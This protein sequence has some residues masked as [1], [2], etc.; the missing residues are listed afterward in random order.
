MTNAILVSTTDVLDGWSIAQHLGIVS[1]HVV[2]GTNVFSDIFASISDIFGGR[3]HTYQRYL[4]D[5]EKEVIAI[6]S[7]KAELLGA[8]CVI[9]LRI[10]HDELS[11]GGKSMFMV[12]AHGTAVFAQRSL[13]G[14]TISL[15]SSEAI[16]GRDIHAI[17][18]KVRLLREAEAGELVLTSEVVD[19]LA[20]HRFPDFSAFFVKQIL[21]LKGNDFSSPIYQLAER[22]FASLRDSDAMPGLYQLAECGVVF[23]SNMIRD[24]SLLDLDRARSMLLSGNAEIARRALEMLTHTKLHYRIEDTNTLENISSIVLELFPEVPISE[25]KGLFSKTKQVWTCSCG[26]NNEPT[27][28]TCAGCL[29]DR[30]GFLPAA[31]KPEYVADLLLRQ[32]EAIR[33]KCQTKT[34]SDTVAAA[35]T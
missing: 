5:I 10:D 26:G 23:A 2:A 21:E 17:A 12:T 1:G 28:A 32:V 14:T 15:R 27:W 22:Y 20:L 11:G 8:N 16:D 33:S 6:V 18:R 35:S 7:R 31:S 13:Q 30:R 9:G 4:M 19:F 3:S 29:R 24:R 34:V 25:T